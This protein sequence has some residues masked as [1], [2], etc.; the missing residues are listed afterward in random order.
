MKILDFNVI[1]EDVESLNKLSVGGLVL[2]NNFTI[3]MAYGRI[4]KVGPGR[5]NDKH[6]TMVPVNLSVGDLVIY[7]PGVSKPI[8]LSVKTA[9]GKS[10]KKKYNKL[11]ANECILVL[12]EDSDGKIVGIKSVKENY[13]LIKRDQTDKKTAGG[14][15]IPEL[16][17]TINN[18]TGTVYAVGPGK[19]DP[20]KNTRV[21]CMAQPGDKVA[22]IEMQS[23]QLSIPV[24]NEQGEVI[25]EKFFEVP[26]SGLDVLMTTDKEGNMNSVKKIKE[27]HVLVQRASGEKK[28]SGGIYLPELD[29]EGH[30]VEATVIMV[31]DNCKTGV[32]VGDKIIYV[33]AKDN[34]KE[35][36]L[37]FQDA[38]GKVETKKCFILP[39]NEIEV[40]LDDGETL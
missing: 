34:N 12:E 25:T 30:L 2:P 5:F 21:P 27:K 38:Q 17:K 8:E 19:Y 4:T 13:V 1:I 20:E 24:K 7:N 39:E 9:D 10:V 29:Q 37:P 31:G 3:P 40:I 23:I 11:T 36:K 15:Y 28:T 35:F 32:A 33:D 16:N 18:I 22:F 6:D 26:D 14:I